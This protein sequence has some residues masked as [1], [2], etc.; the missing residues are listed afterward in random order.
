MN[1]KERATREYKGEGER[2][3]IEWAIKDQKL[4]HT[5]R[6]SPSSSVYTVRS[7]IAVVF[8]FK[9]IQNQSFDL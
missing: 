7:C 4:V 5:V 2:V 9:K 8:T 3:H 1:M 6:S